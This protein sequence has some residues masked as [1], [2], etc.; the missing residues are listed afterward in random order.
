MTYSLPTL[1]TSDL[2]KTAAVI[3]EMMSLISL[4]EPGMPIERLTATII[5]SGSLGRVST[6]RIKDIVQRSFK[7]RFLEPDATAALHMKLAL[8]AGLELGK[9]KELLFLYFIRTYRV[10]KDFLAE[11]YWPAVNAGHDTIDGKEIVSFLKDSFG[12]EQNPA[13]WSE[14]VTARVARN[15]GKALADF[16][17]FETGRTPLRRIR[18][19]EPSDFLVT[20]ILLTRMTLG[21]GP[22]ALLSLDEWA[23]LGLQ[24]EHLIDRCRRIGNTTGPFMFQ[25]SGELAQFTWKTTTVEDL[26]NEY[27]HA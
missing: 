12:T 1:Y 6:V 19:W 22:T 2:Q 11:R 23:A 14:S 9:L 24:R 18:H 3:P 4:W 5:E 8:D 13:G 16:G 21:V 7:Q 25:F 20:Y 27:T 17:L 10:A 15:L 26:I